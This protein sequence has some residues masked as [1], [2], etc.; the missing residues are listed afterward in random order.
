MG[1]R[2]YRDLGGVGSLGG[3]GVGTRGVEGLR[4]GVQG[5]DESGVLGSRWWGLGYG[6]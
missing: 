3:G 1:S 5:C 6:W 2:G 4:F